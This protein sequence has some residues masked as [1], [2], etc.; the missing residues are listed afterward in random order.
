MIRQIKTNSIG[1]NISSHLCEVKFIIHHIL[2][3]K[4]SNSKDE[5]THICF[6]RDLKRHCLAPGRTTVCCM[7]RRGTSNCSPCSPSWSAGARTRSWA[8]C[9]APASAWW[10]A[11]PPTWVRGSRSAATRPWS[12]TCFRKSA[13]SCATPSTPAGTTT[14]HMSSASRWTGTATSTLSR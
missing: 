8:G 4:T 10:C 9:C 1:P 5:K 14:P 12:K 2:N 6:S 3:I 7:R 13:T 11:W